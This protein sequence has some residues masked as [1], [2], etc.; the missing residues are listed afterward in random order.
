VGRRGCKQDK[1][2][3]VEKGKEKNGSREVT[4]IRKKEVRIGCAKRKIR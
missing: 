2:A 1:K 3:K 4:Q